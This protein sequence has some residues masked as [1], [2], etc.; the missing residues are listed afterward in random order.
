M[1]LRVIW[2]YMDRSIY[3]PMTLSAMNY[4]L[5]TIISSVIRALPSEI[6]P[7]RRM[8]LSITSNYSRHDI[9]EILLKV[10][11]STIPYI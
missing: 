9:T 2:Q 8:Y 10:A 3:C 5:Y 1:S 7:I 6:T 4:L 11:L